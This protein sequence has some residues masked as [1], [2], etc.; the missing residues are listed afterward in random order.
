MSNEKKLVL[1]DGAKYA[2]CRPIKE[3]Q[4]IVESRHRALCLMRL[5]E[6]CH[7]CPN[8]KFALV[9]DVPEKKLEQVRCPRWENVRDLWQGKPP[10]KYEV[11]E[12]ATCKERPFPFCGSCPSREELAELEIDKSKDGWLSRWNRFREEDNL[13]D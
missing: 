10:D 9:F 1:G 8:S 13:D 4:Q 2:E 3:D 11:T 5:R 7:V 6:E 12:F